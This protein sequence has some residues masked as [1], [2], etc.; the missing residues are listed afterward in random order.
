MTTPYDLS[1]LRS[2]YQNQ[3]LVERI[4]TKS[5]EHIY[6][7]TVYGVNIRLNRTKAEELI[8]I[9]KAMRVA[10]ETG[11]AR[12]RFDYKNLI[13]K[14]PEYALLIPVIARENPDLVDEEVLNY[15]DE[16]SQFIEDA[17]IAILSKSSKP[18][19][20]SKDVKPKPINLEDV[21]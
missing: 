10:R 12:Q 13:M 16:C 14:A 8:R 9:L 4:H 6:L 11:A 2:G 17:A 19:A 1:G 7:K 20:G 3:Q 21:E 15:Y 18:K 5:T